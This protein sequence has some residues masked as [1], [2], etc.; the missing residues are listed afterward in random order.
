MKVSAQEEYGLRCLL[1]LARRQRSGDGSPLTLG[2]IAR[3]EGLTV[4]HVAKLISRLRK[5]GLVRSVL[6]RTGG[7]TL[8]RD[9]SGVSVSEVLAALGGKLYDTDYCTKFS[10]DLAI[11]THMGD[12]SLRSLW[13][14][15]E[16]LLDRVLKQTKLSELV[17]SEQGMT[18][19]LDKRAPA[20]T[21]R[22]RGCR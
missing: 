4:P 10:G 9:A 14:V 16:T 3:E 11:C 15:L 5:A 7:Y 12:C 22:L 6:G 1:Q 21:P 18:A 2:E 20:E 19:M 17:R 8:A 13:G